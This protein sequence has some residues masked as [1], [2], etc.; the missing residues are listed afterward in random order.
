MKTIQCLKSVL[1]TLF[2]VNAMA[3]T[4]WALDFDSDVSAD[5]KAQVQGDLA[6]IYGVSGSGQ[7]PLHQEIFGTVAGSTYKSFFESRVLEVGLK[8][9]GGNGAVA[10]VIG[11]LAANKMWISPL[12]TRFSHPQIARIMVIFHEA[13]HTENANWHWTHASCPKPFLDEQGHEIVAIWSGAKLAGE[14]ACDT[15]YLGSYGS[16]LIMLR[17]IARRCTN[18]TDKVKMDADLYSTDQINRI[19]D[20]TAKNAIRHDS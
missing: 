4:S 2:L 11:Y 10:C 17:N 1:V 16:S 5:L 18:C 14:K 13:R 8:D 12:Y 15:T 3:A 9:C 20:S 19:I 7:S 6:F